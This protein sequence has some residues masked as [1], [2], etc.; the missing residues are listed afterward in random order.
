MASHN[1]RHWAAL[2]KPSRDSAA[3]G[4]SQR[5]WRPR[6][7]HYRRNPKKSKLPPVSN[8]RFK[9][10]EYPMGFQFS[11]HCCAFLNQICYVYGA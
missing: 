9:F 2:L 10:N 11:D 1:Y 5:R 6:H 3:G 4:Y 8:V 7:S